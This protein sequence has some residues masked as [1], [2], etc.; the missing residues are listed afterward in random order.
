MN[1]II[2]LPDEVKVPEDFPHQYH[3]IKY[4]HTTSIVQ[5]LGSMNIQM[6][7]A[8]ASTV[9]QYLAN[10]NNLLKMDKETP[11]F[12]AGKDLFFRHIRVMNQRTGEYYHNRGATIL[13]DL[14]APE[15]RFFFSYAI[16]NHRD[17]FNKEVAHAVCVDRMKN[18]EV[19]EVINYDPYISIL[20]NIYLAVGVGVDAYTFVENE[21]DLKYIFPEVYTSCNEEQMEA[22]AR[23]RKLIRNKGN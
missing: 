19:I 21:Y 13:V 4:L 7:E 20:Q 3:K 9:S 12:K 23:L 18:G 15:G 14:R 10:I 5:G 1:D 16:C 17:N 11:A 22:L 6:R 2:I 8:G